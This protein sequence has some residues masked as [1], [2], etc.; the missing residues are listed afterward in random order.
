M[1]QGELLNADGRC[2]ISNCM[3]TTS[4]LERMRGLLFRPRPSPF[5]G[6]LIDPCS[7]VHT[8]GMAYP[9]DIVYLDPDLRIIKLEE[10]LKPWRLSRC[11]GARMTLE[12]APGR[13][14][15]LGLEADLR[16]EWRAA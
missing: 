12:L 4:A 10:R 15:A 3:R 5:T 8:V 2:L 11:R 6:L 7:A 16:L 13:A 1:T 14:R 9:I